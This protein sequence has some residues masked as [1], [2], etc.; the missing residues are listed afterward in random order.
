VRFEGTLS[1]DSIP[2][3]IARADALVL[4]SRWDG[5]GLVANEALSVGVPVVISNRCGAADLIHTGVNG[6]V[7]HSEDMLDLRRCLQVWLERRSDW[8][9]LCTAALASGAK[10]SA[11]AVAPYVVACLECIGGLRNERP[12]APWL[13]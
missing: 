4:P 2:Q 5:W 6:W 10:I 9:R 11:E 1:A 12:L 13:Q 3:R 8:P 7:F